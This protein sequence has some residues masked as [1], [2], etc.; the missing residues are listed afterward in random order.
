MDIRIAIMVLMN[1][2]VILTISP[3]DRLIRCKR[4][5]QAS[6]SLITN[7]GSVVQLCTKLYSN[8]FIIF[9]EICNFYGYF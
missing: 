8:I 9:F 7:V 2:V 1:T 5:Y 6:F 4:D 3:G